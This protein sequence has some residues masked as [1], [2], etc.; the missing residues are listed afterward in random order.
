MTALIS[1]KLSGRVLR[2]A[3]LQAKRFSAEEAEKLEIVDKAVEADD[4]LK[5]AI[6]IAAKWAEKVGEKTSCYSEL[7]EG[8][9]REAKVVLTAKL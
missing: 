1:S 9:Y 7:K 4:L 3:V 2:D 6:A 8:L 5:E